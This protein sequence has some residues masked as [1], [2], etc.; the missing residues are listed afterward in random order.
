MHGHHGLAPGLSDF[1]PLL[2]VLLLTFIYIGLVFRQRTRGRSWPQARSVWF[3][4]GMLLVA[5]ALSPW[6]VHAAHDDARWH[7]V[8]HLLTGMYAPV[9]LVLAWPVTLL[10]RS[11]PV[12]QARSVVGL[13][14]SRPIRLIASPPLALL[15]SVGGLHLLYLT[16]LYQLMLSSTAFHWLVQFHLF[17]AGMLFAVVIAQVEPGA[18]RWSLPL[19][20][21]TLFVGMAAHANLAKIMYARLLPAGTAAGVE[22]LQAAAQLM[23]YGG[24]L[25]EVLLA[26]VVFW[27]WYERRHP[28]AESTQLAPV[29][30]LAEHGQA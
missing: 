9:A 7:M 2:V 20:L 13:L 3:A 19:R 4:V 21:G 10:L 14:H 12:G 30:Q 16:P 27:V 29:S 17:A 18:P 24:D 15:L 5:C 11:L 8:Q 22:E 6:V 28:S 1:V 26:V 23:Y 25:A